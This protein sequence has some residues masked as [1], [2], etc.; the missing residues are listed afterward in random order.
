MLR[1]PECMA[2]DTT[3]RTQTMAQVKWCGAGFDPLCADVNP[4]L[5]DADCAWCCA[6]WP[7]AP[8]L[9][10]CADELELNDPVGNYLFR[11]EVHDVG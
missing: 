5:G 2:R 9:R 11:V 3:T 8:T 7:P 1:D 4:V 10:P 6:A